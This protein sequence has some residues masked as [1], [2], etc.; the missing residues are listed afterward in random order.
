VRVKSWSGGVPLYRFSKRVDWNEM[1]KVS[2]AKKARSR[3][4]EPDSPGSPAKNENGSKPAREPA[5]IA[6]E[7]VLAA[8]SQEELRAAFW[9]IGEGKAGDKFVP[10]ANHIAMAMVNP[11]QGFAHWRIHQSWIDQTA[12]AKGGAWHNCRLIVRLYDVTCIE[13]NGFNAH[14]VIN[15]PVHTIC[16]HMLFNLHKP[17][18]NLIAEV[19]FE[20]TNREFI[21]AARSAV[22]AMPPTGASARGSHAGLLV[23]EK[24]RIKEVA[25]VWE[26]EKVLADVKKPRLKKRLRVAKFAF[27]SAACGNTGVLATF[28][29]ELGTGLKQAGHDVHVFL[30]KSEQLSEDREINGVTYHPLD[31]APANGPVELALNYARAAENLL[32]EMDQFDLFHLHE[33]MTGLAPWIGTCP[34]VLSLTS[35][36]KTRL[37]GGEPS[38]LSLEVQKIE[39]ELVQVVECVLTPQWLR[40][41][42]IAEFGVEAQKIRDFPMEGR[43]PNEWDCELDIGKVKQEFGFGVFDRLLLYIGPLNYESGLDVLVE[44]LPVA[45]GR[46][47]DLRIAVVGTGP[48]HDSL[49]RRAWD[50][51]KGHCV[52]MLGEVGGPRLT[53][54]LR[55]SEALILP[56]R[57]R[58]HGDEAVVDLARRA[59]RA[60]VTT[61]GGP[62]HLVRHEENGIITYDNPGSMVW[63]LDRV[64]GD[65]NHTKKMGQN[66]RRNDSGG[67]SWKEVAALYLDV[68]AERFPELTTRGE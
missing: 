24:L 28:V 12:K 18:T 16:G 7:P 32:S 60:V 29:A 19:G 58:V 55:A 22:V 15:M 21:P 25:N 41:K 1:L 53:K 54:L 31:I 51:G 9:K 45:A 46:V 43:I 2:S 66:G 52:K 50:L 44:A 6:P 26:H 57:R 8:P 35:T 13:F 14:Q 68:C 3:H 5:V 11:G 48:M 10:A 37:N 23:D 20:L 63:A 38:A 33:W 17:G 61:H 67:Y 64:L 56:S 40:E 36:E 49:L 39:H 4:G 30:P 59:G 34:T 62:G 47:P 42:A 27:E 65:A